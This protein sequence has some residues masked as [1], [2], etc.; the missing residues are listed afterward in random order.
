MYKIAVTDYGYML[1]FSGAMDRAEM[2]KWRVESKA[3]LGQEKRVEF[4]V[5]IDMRDLRPLPADAQPVME[6]GQELYKAKGM[7]R[8]C[9]ILSSSIIALQFKKLAKES[10]I[11]AVERY[12]D[13]T[14]APDWEQKAIGWLTKKIDPDIA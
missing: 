2:E 4:G 1:T 14:K 3:I 7:T 8:S 5:L 12:I 13:A 10:G 6:A 9:V 11:Y